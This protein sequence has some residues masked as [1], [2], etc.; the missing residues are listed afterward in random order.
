MAHDS[1]GADSH[2]GFHAP[3]LS[4]A[5]GQLG[6]GQRMRTTGTLSAGAAALTCAAALAAVLAVLAP[7]GAARAEQPVPLGASPLPDR[8]EMRFCYF[9]GLAYSAGA[10]VT[11]A[12]PV[13]PEVVTDR[14]RKQLRCV[15]DETSQ[16]RFYWRELDPDEG[17]PFRN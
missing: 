4:L 16:G 10:V 13:R 17:D 12:V 11:V 9:S 5:S 6:Q 14:P 3:P 8:V 15:A 2:L 7:G 1:S